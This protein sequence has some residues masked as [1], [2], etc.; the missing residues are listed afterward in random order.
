MN[1]PTTFPIIR[2]N[3]NCGDSLVVTD[4]TTNPPV[5]GLTM[6]ERTGSRIFHYLW[7]SHRALTPKQLQRARAEASST[8][9]IIILGMMQVSKHVPFDDPFVLNVVRAVY[10]ASSAIPRLEEFVLVMH[11]GYAKWDLHKIHQIANTK[12]P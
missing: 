8:N 12:R 11:E 9:L 7:S 6:G 10:L 2:G 5:S 1:H 3:I 4:P